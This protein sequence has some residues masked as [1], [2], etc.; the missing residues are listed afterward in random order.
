MPGAKVGLIETL[1]VRAGRFPFLERHLAR[2]R[3]SLAE[4]GLPPVEL[5][6][7]AFARGPDRAVRIQLVDGAVD[8]TTRD[9]TD[10][11]PV[12]IIAAEPHAPY[13]R[14]T[15]QRAPFER[16]LAEAQRASAD[17][18]LLVTPGGTVAEGTAWSLF[19]WESDGLRTPAADLGVLPGVGRGRVMELAAVREAR[20]SPVALV[21]RSAFLVNAVR[22]IVPLASLAGHAVPP[23]PRTAELSRRFW[24]D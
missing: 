11:S 19:W 14:K 6:L 5:R 20:V 12:V 7:G 18:A 24:P 2:L 23:D 22:G 16:A 21:G 17:D 15:T 9:V 3:R 1:R 4:L 13:P 10:R 8:V